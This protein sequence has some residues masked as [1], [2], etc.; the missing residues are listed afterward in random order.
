MSTYP[1][2]LDDLGSTNPTPTTPTNDGDGHA[3][4][5]SAANDA[6]DAIQ[7]TLG[8]NPFGVTL[9][10]DATGGTDGHVLTIDTG[11]WV[12]AEPTGGGGG[13]LVLIA[14]GTVSG[15]SIGDPALDFDALF[16]TDFDVVEFDMS[17]IIGS[18]YGEIGVQLRASGTPLAGS[19]YF[20]RRVLTRLGDGSG[21]GDVGDNNNLGTD[22]WAGGLFDNTNPSSMLIT[23]RHAARAIRTQFKSEINAW[24][25]GAHWFGGTTGENSSTS[26]YDGLA[27]RP[28]S[29]TISFDWVARGYAK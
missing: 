7:A 21:S 10:P 17:A 23:V 1:G 26:A 3:A 27:I 15:A 12:A 16:T 28:T 8:V 9:L 6:I 5:H 25:N 18:T 11:E 20:A 2:A 4:Q 29:G 14:S 13:G 19:G 22:E 24:V